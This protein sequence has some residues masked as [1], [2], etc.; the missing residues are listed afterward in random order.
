MSCERLLNRAASSDKRKTKH[1]SRAG[2]SFDAGPSQALEQS[3]LETRYSVHQQLQA[4]AGIHGRIE[5]ASGSKLQSADFITEFRLRTGYRS[6]SI[7][8]L[9]NSPR[10]FLP[11]L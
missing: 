9:P 11:L 2:N 4:M 1:A 10:L 8:L 6:H 7:S 3:P 5:Q